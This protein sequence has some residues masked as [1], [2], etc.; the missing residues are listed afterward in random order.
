M[1]PWM[2]LSSADLAAQLPDGEDQ[3]VHFPQALV[4]TVLAEYTT[5]GQT[6]LDPFAGFGTTL[7]TAQRMG[8]RSVGVELLPERVELIRRRLTGGADA[9]VINGDARKLRTLVPGPVDLCL[10]SPPYMDAVGHPEN[11]LNA[12]ETLDGDY[13]TYLDEIGDIFEQVAQ[14]LRP[15]GYAVVNVANMRIDGQTTFLAWDV[16][17]VISAHLTLC[18]EVLLCWDQPPAWLTGDYCLVFQ[19]PDE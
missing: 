16:G 18:Q 13:P 6:V 2:H 1:K 3:E 7:V 11:P 9:E 14:V 17:K 10:T 5:P 15:G 4:E 12:Y 8:R 19:R